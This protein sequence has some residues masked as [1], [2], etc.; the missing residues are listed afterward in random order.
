MAKRKDYKALV[1]KCIEK[2]GGN[3]TQ[4][5]FAINDVMM[6]L[7]DIKISDQRLMYSQK[8]DK[9]LAGQDKIDW[10]VVEAMEAYCK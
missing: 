7:F 9:I 1:K 3:K 4:A 2:T 6:T 5:S 10:H 8:L